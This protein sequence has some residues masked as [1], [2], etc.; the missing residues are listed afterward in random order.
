MISI[1]V[2][3]PNSLHLLQPFDA[4][5]HQSA[6]SN[7]SPGFRHQLFG[8]ILSNW[9]TLAGSV[10]WIF[11]TA[12][13][14]S[15]Y[16][17]LAWQACALGWFLWIFGVGPIEHDP[18]L[19]EVLEASFSRPRP[20]PLRCTPS[21]PSGHTAAV[22]LAIGALLFV[23]L[24]VVYGNRPGGGGGGK[25][26]A[27]AVA[28]GDGNGGARS[29]PVLEFIYSVQGSWGLWALS[30]VTTAVGRLGVDAHWLS[31]TLA[32]GALSVALVSGLAK[33]TERLVGDGVG[34]NRR[35]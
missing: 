22:V 16:N 11:T 14:I 7:T 18:L 5:I 28:G 34:K 10:G 27:A 4:A 32:G 3:S 23:L 29:H 6:L 35:Q 9:W 26:G 2:F 31:D 8:N 19:M 25:K 24:P 20:S 1:D 13:A 33:A 30:A 15:R 21:F 17:P 12:T